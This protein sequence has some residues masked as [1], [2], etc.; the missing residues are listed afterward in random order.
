[1][2]FSP[3][4]SAINFAYPYDSDY[5]YAGEMG[6]IHPFHP[7]MQN[8]TP[9]HD[10]YGNSD[11]Q[12]FW[13]HWTHS[14]HCHSY[15]RCLAFVANGIDH[16]GSDDTTGQYLDPAHWT[17]TESYVGGGL[18]PHYATLNQYQ[19]I[20]YAPTASPKLLPGATLKVSF[21]MKTLPFGDGYAQ[22]SD[23]STMPVSY[24]HLTLPTI[25]SV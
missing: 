12:L 15:G 13:A 22:A 14:N 18:I 21:W 9:L 24:T 2:N 8:S 1:M 10:G 3:I 16:G 7:N 25:C 6:Y 17:A 4:P 11:T 5:F 20:Y 19:N 23:G